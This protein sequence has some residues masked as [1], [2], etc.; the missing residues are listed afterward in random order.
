M[1]IVYR[2]TSKI[3]NKFYIG[4]KT[5]CE[6]IDGKILDKK[7]IFYYSSCKN[8]DFWEELGKGNL[9]LDIIEANVEN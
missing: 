5:E 3:T 1:N 7:G 4:S 8:S 6:V 2:F 9:L